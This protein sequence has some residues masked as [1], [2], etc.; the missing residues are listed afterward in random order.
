MKALFD[1]SQIEPLD[2]APT[3]GTQ[4]HGGVDDSRLLRGLKRA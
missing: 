1:E 3:R 2:Y 4:L